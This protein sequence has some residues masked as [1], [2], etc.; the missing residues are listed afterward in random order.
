LIR[1]GF[2]SL[3]VIP[4]LFLILM[5][6][7]EYKLVFLV[8]WILILIAV[9]IYLICVEYFHEQIQQQ[10]ALSGLTLDDLLQKIQEEK[11]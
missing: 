3:L 2:R 1:F 10:L 4:S 8:L 5:F 6:T 11:Q 9:A 7:L